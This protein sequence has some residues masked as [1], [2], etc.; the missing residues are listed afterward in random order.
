MAPTI[1]RV[2]ASFASIVESG[3]GSAD[4]GAAKCN[5]TNEA[6]HHITMRVRFSCEFNLRLHCW[7]AQYNAAPERTLANLVNQ[8]VGRFCAHP[9]TRNELRR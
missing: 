3:I 5:I 7:D 2:G 9:G 1:S 4:N 6:H 8:P